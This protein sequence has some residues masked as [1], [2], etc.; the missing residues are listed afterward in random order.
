MKQLWIT[1]SERYDALS[2]R[3]R[4]MVFG[5]I[6]AGLVYVVYFAWMEPIFTKQ[7]VLQTKISQMQNNVAGIDREI[8]STVRAYSEDPDAAARQRVA[9]LQVQVE[10]QGEAL[11]NAQK[12]LVAPERMAQLIE[13]ILKSHRGL[14]LQSFKTLPVSGLNELAAE[15]VKEAKPAAPVP[16]EE[17]VAANLRAAMAGAGPAAPAAAGAPP[18]AAAAAAPAGAAVPA[19]VA[20]AAAP[21]A[22][23]KASELLYRHGVEITVEGKYLDMVDFMSALE[24]MPT[25]LFWGKAKLDVDEF[26]KARLTL[27]LYTMSLEKKWM[28]L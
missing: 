7:K 19:P 5:A 14:R 18:L 8:E 3:E 1:Y 28:K 20:P 2:L 21:K 15:P 24:A 16:Q 11:R 12:E 25:Q 17:Q 27:T 4:L 10:Q 26:P 22:A 13:S 6:A 23:P 9:K